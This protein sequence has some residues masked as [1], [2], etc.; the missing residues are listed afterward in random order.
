MVTSG[1]NPVRQSGR[2]IRG[3]VKIASGT[4]FNHAQGID[5]VASKAGYR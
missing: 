2:Y 5:F 3:N 1:I 4:S